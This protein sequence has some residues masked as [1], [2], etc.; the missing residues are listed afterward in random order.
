VFRQPAYAWDTDVYIIDIVGLAHPVGSHLDELSGGRMGHQKAVGLAWQL[1]GLADVEWVR[2]E[3]GGLLATRDELHSANRTT[4]CG[5]LGDYLAG[6][7]EPLTPARFLEN[8]V[9]SFANT[10]LLVPQDP[11]EAEEAL[12]GG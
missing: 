12:C 8:I 2:S 3:D 10:V 11:R 1:A 5:Q 7:R 9:D 4:T 6:I